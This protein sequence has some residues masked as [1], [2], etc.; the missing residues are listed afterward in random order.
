MCTFTTRVSRCGHYT[1]SLS[2]PCSDAKKKKEVCDGGS[3]V[4]S[5]T[6]GWCFLGGCDK[7]PNMMRDGP[8]SQSNTLLIGFITDSVSGARK[9]GGFES[10]QIDWD[11]YTS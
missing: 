1:K 8:G 10:S 3:E 11:D 5:T 4:S 9:N 6:G 7:E 2:T